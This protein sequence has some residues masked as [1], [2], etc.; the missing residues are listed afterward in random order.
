M[1]CHIE[2]H[3]KS[4]HLNQIYTGF[5]LLKKNGL[6]DLTWEYKKKSNEPWCKVILNNKIHIIYDTY[7]SGNKFADEKYINEANFYFKRSYPKNNKNEKIIPLGL[8]YN[9]TDKFYDFESIIYRLKNIIKGIIKKKKYNF[10]TKDFEWYPLINDNSKICFLTRLWD[11]DAD[12]V[13]NEKVKNERIEINKFR[14]ECIKRCKEEFKEDF[15][16]GIQRDSYS[17]KNYP[18]YVVDDKYTQKEEFLKIMKKSDICIATTGLHESIGW[19]FGEYVA[20][21]RA[22]VSEKL[23]Y[24]LPG[25]F[26]ENNNYL[27]FNNVED[28]INKIYLLKNNKT[29]RSKIMENNYIYYN[30]YLRPDKLILNTLL[31]CL[32]NNC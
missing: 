5:K 18:E 15:L 25:I 3:S 10:Y 7:D 11:P 22:I 24:S 30:C 9:V 31:Y 13:E 14:I 1:K 8:N 2:I 4:P 19:K 27:E 21:S 29:A 26:S 17:L 23:N 32:K 28:L 6:I 16:G 20:A 12:D